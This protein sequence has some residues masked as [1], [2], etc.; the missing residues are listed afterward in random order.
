MHF[1]EIVFLIESFL[2][3]VIQFGFPPFQFG[4]LAP[5]ISSLLNSVFIDIRMPIFLSLIF[6]IASSEC[7]LPLFQE[8]TPLLNHSLFLITILY[9]KP[10]GLAACS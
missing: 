9:L 5:N 6:L 10:V 8:V 7:F 1:P 3:Q 4:F 2:K